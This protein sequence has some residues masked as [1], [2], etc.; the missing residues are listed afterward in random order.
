MAIQCSK[1]IFVPDCNYI[2]LSVACSKTHFICTSRNGSQYNIQVLMMMVRK[3]VLIGVAALF[4][5][6]ACLLIGASALSLTGVLS[7]PFL[8]PHAIPF[9]DPHAISL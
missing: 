9:L 4:A 3:K 5:I 8:D 7:I 1:F 2:S 6:S